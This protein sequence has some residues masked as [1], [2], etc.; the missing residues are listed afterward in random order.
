[1]TGLEWI[2]Y[3]EAGTRAAF[4]L[5]ATWA[6]YVLA[7]A[8]RVWLLAKALRERDGPALGGPWRTKATPYNLDPLREELPPL[9]NLDGSSVVPG[10][11]GSRGATTPPSDGW[12]GQ[13]AERASSE[14]VI[15][16]ARPACPMFARRQT[17]WRARD[18][19]G[20]G[21]CSICSR[22]WLEH[23]QVPGR[24]IVKPPAAPDVL[25]PRRSGRPTTIERDPP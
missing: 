22:P 3:L 12:P 17:Y 19:D 14:G 5:A 18:R 20:E 10:L 8:V 2:V 7:Q 23:R 25:P 16:D 13:G 11:S 6:L 21:L 4:T 1:M 24:T 9:R 15:Y